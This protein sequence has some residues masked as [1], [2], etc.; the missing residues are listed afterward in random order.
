MYLQTAAEPRNERP[1]LSSRCCRRAL[2]FDGRGVLEGFEK[3]VHDI[4][5]VDFFKNICTDHSVQISVHELENKINIA[6]VVRF[7]HIP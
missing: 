3:L 6:V 1:Y 4:L 5:L 7:E 2:G